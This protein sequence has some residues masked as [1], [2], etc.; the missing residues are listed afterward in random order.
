MLISQ[1]RLATAHYTAL[2]VNASFRKRQFDLTI[3]H[4]FAAPRVPVHIVLADTN[5]SQESELQ[6]F[7]SLQDAFTVSPMCPPS[8][9]GVDEATRQA[10]LFATAPTFGH[11]YPWVPGAPRKK[12]RTPRRL[13]RIWVK[14]A[15]PLA[16]EELGGVEPVRE[17]E[18]GA[19]MRD[20]EG[21]DG[22]M[23]ESDHVG[24]RVTVRVPR[25]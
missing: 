19:R 21:R 14:G 24:V 3:R 9:C 2:T 13:D 11:L 20:G 10:Q 17:Q 1:L 18:G 25:A 8:R 4:L 16:Y 23:W 12:P 7:H 15:V 5:A 6:P 22:W